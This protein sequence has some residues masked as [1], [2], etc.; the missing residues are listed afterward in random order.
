MKKKALI[1]SLNGTK[2]SKMEKIL[3]SKEKPWGVILFKRNLKSKK[4]IKNLTKN[5]RYLTNDTKFPII[6]DEEGVKVSRLRNIINHNISASFF[7]NLFKKNRDF[8]SKIYQEYIFS[9]CQI[10]NELGININTIPVL[11][12]IRKN[13]NKVIGNRSFSNDR[14]IVQQL[15]KLTLKYLHKKKIAGIIKHIPGHGAATVDSHKKLP[16]VKLHLKK[17]NKIDFYPFKLSN[18]KLAMTAHILYTKL[19]NRNAATHSK[20]I[21]KEII[22]KKIGFKGI[23]ISDD[24]SMNALKYDL[25]TNATKSIEAGCNLVLYCAGKTNDN[26]KLIKSLPYIDKFTSKKTSEFYKFLM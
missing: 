12:V 10:L 17:L 25:I 4:Q 15:G 18:A 22:R 3:L 19:D 1:V 5:I 24:I 2:L 11:D 6:I 21:I 8:C 26:F 23:L 14:K 20:K 9:L 7:G 13:T 16:K